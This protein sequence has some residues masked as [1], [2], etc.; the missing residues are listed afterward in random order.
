MY[1]FKI[2]QIGFRQIGTEPW[3]HSTKTALRWGYAVCMGR[4]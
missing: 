3:Y 4:P 1:F 2:Q